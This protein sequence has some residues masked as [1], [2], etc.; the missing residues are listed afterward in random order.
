LTNGLKKHH[1]CLKKW[2]KLT[3]KQKLKDKVFLA[4]VLGLKD[5]YEVV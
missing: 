4:I 2:T 3:A 5:L 1:D